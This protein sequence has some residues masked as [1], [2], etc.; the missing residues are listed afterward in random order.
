MTIKNNIRYYCTHHYL[1]V[2]RKE[3]IDA[4]IVKLY[5]IDICWIEQYKPESSFIQE[6][7]L[8]SNIHAANKEFLSAAELS[9][10]YKHYLAIRNISISKID[11]VIFED[12]IETPPFNFSDT[13][14]SLHELM[15]NQGCDILFVGSFAS[16]DL[17]YKEPTIV[18]NDSTQSRCAH[19]YIVRCNIASK[20]EQYLFEPRMPLDWQLNYAIKDLG[21]RSGWSWPHIY[22]R[23][24]K[25]ILRS[26]LR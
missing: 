14:T 25:N 2:D 4:N 22:Q 10:Y 3:Y 12:D 7:P 17:N 8:V 18:M 9:C 26:L 1:A 11:G 15:I 20:L 21:L 19:C 23:T 6:H 16:H 5:N 13:L 24:E